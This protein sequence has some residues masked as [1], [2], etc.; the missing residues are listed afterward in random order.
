MG[1]KLNAKQNQDFKYSDIKEIKSNPQTN[2]HHH[3]QNKQWN[4]THPEVV[5]ILL[6]ITY[7]HLFFRQFQ[8]LPL[9]SLTLKGHDWN[10][11]A[12]RETHQGKAPC[13][14]ISQN[15]ELICFSDWSLPSNPANRRCYWHRKCFYQASCWQKYLVLVVIFLLL[16]CKESKPLGRQLCLC[17]ALHK[18]N[19]S[20]KQRY[21][22]WFSLIVSALILSPCINPV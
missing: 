20:K 14:W 16:H 12:S 4:T 9:Y 6:S 11:R 1:K 3:H 7:G 15:R 2:N 22:F 8:F 5:S 19:W 10:L 17:W 18:C 13:W 21:S